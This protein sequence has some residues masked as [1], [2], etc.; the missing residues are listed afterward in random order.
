MADPRPGGFWPFDPSSEPYVTPESALAHFCERYEL[1]PEQAALP[2]VMIATFQGAAHDRLRE[3][4]EA[5]DPLGGPRLGGSGSLGELGVGVWHGRPITL[6]RITVGAPAA[7]LRIENCIARGV[8]TVLIVGS[9]G[10]LQPALPIGSLVVIDAAE[11]EGAEGTP[12]RA[13]TA[14]GFTPSARGPGRVSHHYLPAGEVVSAD[15]G[16]ARLLEDEGRSLGV[17]VTRGRSWTIDAPYRET[18]AAVLRHR[19]AGVAVVEMEAAAIFAVARIRGIRAG[20]IVAVS[21]EL[22][23]RWN[24]G[25][26]HPVYLTGLETAT[27]AALAVAAAL[28]A[29]GAPGE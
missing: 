4:T 2:P 8:R 19:A 23:D 5:V 9:A 18:V 28:D 15:G 6:A 14:E 25:F 27:D 22:F 12:P 10:R 26:N 3:R 13:L 21:D 24:P 7:T 16:I 29:S 17:P 11:R 20:L 1:T